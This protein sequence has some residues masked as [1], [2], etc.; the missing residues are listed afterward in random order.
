MGPTYTDL[1]CL[2][3]NDKAVLCWICGVKASDNTLS[4]ALLARL[5][6]LDVAVYLPAQRLQWFGSAR[7][8][9]QSPLVEEE[10]SF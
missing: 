3:C 10:V 7:S 4:E 8:W 9:T 5:S 6:S 1:L 2:S